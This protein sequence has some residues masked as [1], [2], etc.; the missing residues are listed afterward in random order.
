[1]KKRKRKIKYYA[2]SN[3]Y[4]Q[5]Y[6]NKEKMVKDCKENWGETVHCYSLE[7]IDTN[8][9]GWQSE[10]THEDEIMIIENEKIIWERK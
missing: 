4:S 2:V 1:M 3:N 5:G 10:L 6:N 7:N 8:E 9:Y